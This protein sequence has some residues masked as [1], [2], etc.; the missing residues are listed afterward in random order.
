MWY[1]WE[2][3]YLR[4]NSDQVH[5]DLFDVAAYIWMIKQQVLLYSNQFSVFTWR[6]GGHVGVQNNS[7]ESLLGIWFYYHAKRERHFAKVFV[8]YTRFASFFFF[9]TLF[10][11]VFVYYCFYT[12]S[13]LQKLEINIHY[14]IKS[15]TTHTWQNN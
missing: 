10:F 15:Y 6:H 13:T 4:M 5:D 1:S 7:N 9:F 2:W 14:S 8:H 12:Y 3:A 11:F